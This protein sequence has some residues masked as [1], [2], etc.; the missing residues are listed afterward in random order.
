MFPVYRRAGFAP[1]KTEPA[2]PLILPRR[3]IILAAMTNPPQ[4]QAAGTPTAP[5]A[6][7][8]HL[9]D[10]IDAIDKQLVELL[11]QRGRVV[12]QV[13]QVK[14]QHDLPTFHPA[15]EENLISAR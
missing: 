13:T 1:R 5:K 14:Q 8:D 7:L 15:R 4:S 3:L 11:A 12:Q 2:C 9:R 10:Q 6:G